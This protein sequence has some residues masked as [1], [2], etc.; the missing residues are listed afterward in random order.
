MY[1][2][3]GIA[4]RTMSASRPVVSIGALLGAQALGGA[5]NGWYNRVANWVGAQGPAAS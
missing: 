2:L 1:P 5:I 4:R 3:R